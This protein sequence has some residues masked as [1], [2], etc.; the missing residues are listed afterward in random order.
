MSGQQLPAGWISQLD[1]ASG[2]TFYVYTA[3]G[4]T[5]WDFPTAVPAPP[6][7]GAQAPINPTAPGRLANDPLSNAMG[8]N[9]APGG[10]MPTP[11]GVACNIPGLEKLVTVQDLFVKQDIQALEALSGGCCEFNNKYK[12]LNQDGHLVYNAV[13]E[14]GACFRCCCAPHH[15]FKV[16]FTDENGKQ[17]ALLDRPFKCTGCCPALL[18][19]CRSRATVAMGDD[20]KIRS[21]IYQPGGGG[22]FKPTY[23][24]Y[25]GE[26][27]TIDMP[28]AAIKNSLLQSAVVEGPWC[29]FGGFF[30]SDFVVRS[31]GEDPS[32]SHV[33]GNIT[34]EGTKDLK[35]AARELLTDADNFKINFSAE[36][37][38]LMRAT[39][40]ANMVVLDFMFF[41]NEGLFDCGF[42]DGGVFCSVRPCDCYCYGCLCPCVLKL[43]TKDC[44]GG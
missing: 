30:E 4:Q 24:F 16:A 33:Y 17:V 3:T 13:E 12:V 6:P 10:W 2:R 43:N 5:Q 44:Q 35:S 22:G 32:K 1:P 8:L 39:M 37:E 31:P 25:T 41:E 9:Q 42:E 29:C 20:Q 34:K 18:P 15:S 28:D 19:C 26:N 14:S 38:P 21:L 36:A 23:N 7:Q 27:I 11:Q 40:M